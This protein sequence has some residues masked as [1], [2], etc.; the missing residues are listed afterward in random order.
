MKDKVDPGSFQVAAIQMVGGEDLQANLAAAEKLIGDAASAGASLLVLPESFAL[1]G[2]VDYQKI[3]ELEATPEGPIRQ[4]LADQARRYGVWIVGGT[5]PIAV[6]RANKNSH[7]AR[8]ATV[9]STTHSTTHATMHAASLVINDEGKEVGRYNK[10]HLF[11]AELKDNQRLYTES[12]LFLP[13][14]EILCVETPFGRLGVAICYDWLFPETIRQIAFNGAEV[15]IRVSAYMDPWGAT[16]PM[17]WW[18]LFNRARA[19]EN[20]V[21]VVASNQGATL[22]NYPPFSWPG[23]SMVVD[24]DGRI[25]AQADPG[26]G[27][28]IVVAPINIQALRDERKRRVGH[29]MLSHLRSEVH[30]YMNKQY[31]A[32]ATK[33]QPLT[34]ESI[35]QRIDDAK[36]RVGEQQ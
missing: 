1:I 33:G 32:P 6:A 13:G 34:G 17:D 21:F 5:I 4:F 27:E 29:D 18:T 8:H 23:G 14:N 25:L 20:T 36:K 19:A 2:N 10:I 3:A 24:Y 11:D 16:P 31:L 26:E 12:D 30:P 15:I 7:A 35:R 9:H 28:K 22:K